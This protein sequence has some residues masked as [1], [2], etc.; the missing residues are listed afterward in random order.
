MPAVTL[1]TEKRRHLSKSIHLLVLKPAWKYSPNL[2]PCCKNYLLIYKWM[3]RTERDVFL[4]SLMFS[5]WVVSSAVP[6][7]AKFH[8]FIYFYAQLSAAWQSRY[9]S[10]DSGAHSSDQ[11]VPGWCR[12][13]TWAAPSLTP[14]AESPLKWSKRRKKSYFHL[15]WMGGRITKAKRAIW[16]L[17]EQS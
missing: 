15:F 13:C 11:P 17:S 6:V 16:V 14:R 12:C 9:C 1:G 4:P 3:R 2:F 7:F 10:I 8:L 5:G